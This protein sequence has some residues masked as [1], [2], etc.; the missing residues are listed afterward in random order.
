M[1]QSLSST[2]D[3]AVQ[4]IQLIRKL[5]R[6]RLQ[7]Y[8][9][10]TADAL[11]RNKQMSILL[12]LALGPMLMSLILMSA[13]PILAL[14][15]GGHVVQSLVIWNALIAVSMIWV[16]VQ[17]QALM[18]G[19]PNQYLQ[20]L[21]IS[22]QQRLFTDFGVLF[23]TNIILFMPYMVALLYSVVENPRQLLGHAVLTLLWMSTVV[24]L[25][26]QFL[27]RIRGRM[28]AAM[29]SV[30]SPLLLCVIDFPLISVVVALVYM[31]LLYAMLKRNQQS[32]TLKMLWL[33]QRVQLKASDSIRYNLIRIYA[34]QLLQAE[35][36]ARLII[37]FIVAVSPLV[38]IPMVDAKIILE[39]LLWIR[40]QGQ[41]LLFFVISVL[42]VLPISVL[43]GFQLPLKTAYQMQLNF[44]ISQGVSQHLIH[45]AQHTMLFLLGM[46]AIL[47]SLITAMC[48][49]GNLPRFLL[50]MTTLAMLWISIWLY[51]KPEDL[52]VVTKMVLFIVNVMI[53]RFILAM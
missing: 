25:Q 21:P 37:L 39:N 3:H 32:K 40:W 2:S 1:K 38:I 4:S 53:I 44:L 27:Y 18:G 24:L 35:N 17:R 7:Y 42:M 45:Q 5:V 46:V 50:C 48:F 14:L 8:V 30:L 52:H 22:P 13:K 28:A 47:P 15:N 16:I 6:W 41:G 34:R 43:V 36:Y 51:R 26:L 9:Y 49:I 31:Y 23:C 10:V 33:G 20:C 12:I 19:V 29:G 11:S